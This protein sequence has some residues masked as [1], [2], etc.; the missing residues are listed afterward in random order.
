MKENNQKP[1]IVEI[2]HNLILPSMVAALVFSILYDGI[3]ML[4]SFSVFGISLFIVIYYSLRKALNDT[5]HRDD[6]DDDIFFPD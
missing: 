5:Q 2:A 3:G 1:I 4:V 6:D